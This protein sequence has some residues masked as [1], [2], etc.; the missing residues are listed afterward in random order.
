MRVDTRAGSQDLIAPLKAAGLPVEPAILASGDITI[1]GRGLDGKSV[2]IGIEY[3]TIPDLLACVRNGRY[4][5]QLRAMRQT[6]DVCWLL[7][8]GRWQMGHAG[9]IDVWEND[10]LGGH[11]AD[12][13]HYPY[14]EVASWL[15][16]MSQ[17][18]G[19]LLWRTDTQAETVAWLRSLYWWWMSKDFES[20]RAHLDWYTPPTACENPFREPSPAQRF[21]IT[22]PGIDVK[23]ETVAKHFG[24]IN[25]MVNASGEEWQQVEGIGKV[26]AKRLVKW[27]DTE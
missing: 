6:Y 1:I 19:A 20:H 17:A 25:K 15:Q 7:I 22:L 11:W 23:A 27:M 8:E 21:A 10:R 24:T 12:R 3:K 14:L 26:G 18:G 5:E 13:G 2:P 16:T 4:A 9:F